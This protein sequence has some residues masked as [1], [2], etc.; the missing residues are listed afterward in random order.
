M[1]Y[2]KGGTWGPWYPGNE[3]RWRFIEADS[4][5]TVLQQMWVSRHNSGDK[6][7]EE[8]RDVPIVGE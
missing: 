3:L 4:G 5:A 1:V 6:V 8:W 2:E 7:K